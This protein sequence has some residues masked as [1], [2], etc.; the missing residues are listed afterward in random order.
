MQKRV[1]IVY[2]HPNPKSF[3][4]ALKDTAIK[5]LQEHGA[6]VRFKDLY[7]GRF[8]PVLTG[9]EIARTRSGE[10]AEDIKKEQA[11]L[12]W[13]TH[14]ILIYPIWWVDRPAIL[15]GWFDRVFLYGFAHKGA[16]GGLLEHEKA[17]VL[18]TAGEPEEFYRRDG[19]IPPFHP[20]ITEGTL[21]YCGID[22]VTV[23]TYYGV[24]KLEPAQREA[25]LEKTKKLVTGWIS[26]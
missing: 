15:K 14:M 1:L 5:T 2:A 26:A 18:Q 13:S 20:T 11:D 3:T 21:H 6:E 25:L 23:E 4:S 16:K 24:P 9:A 12:L 17:L 8:D 19:R 7:A 22:D 10:I